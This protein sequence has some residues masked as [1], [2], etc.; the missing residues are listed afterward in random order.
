MKIIFHLSKVKGYSYTVL[1]LVINLFYFLTVCQMYALQD[2]TNDQN[3][4]SGQNYDDWLF[5]VVFAHIFAKFCISCKYGLCPQLYCL[6]ALPLGGY[7]IFSGPYA[8][9]WTNSTCNGLNMCTW[10]S[11]MGQWKQTW[12]FLY[13][14]KIFYF[15]CCVKQKKR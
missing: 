15:C 12:N 4:I 2:S 10:Q 5:P 14:I 1:I 8:E 3:T 11:S 7:S 6:S 13:V 9:C